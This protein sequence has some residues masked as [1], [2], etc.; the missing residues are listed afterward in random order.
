MS[1]IQ[2]N[3]HDLLQ[4]VLREYGCAASQDFA[5]RQTERFTGS[6]DRTGVG[7][8]DGS[9]LAMLV[10]AKHDIAIIAVDAIDDENAKQYAAP[11]HPMFERDAAG[12]RWLV[13]MASPIVEFSEVDR[14]PE[15]GAHRLTSEVV[16]GQIVVVVSTMPL[17]YNSLLREE[18]EK[19]E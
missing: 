14:L 6:I 2:V 3:R 15:V 16:F 11:L 1:A 10:T 17:T 8:F 13:S 5:H 7:R 19:R 9:E 12:G 18:R 4:A